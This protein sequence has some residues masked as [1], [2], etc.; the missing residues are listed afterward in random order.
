MSDLISAVAIIGGGIMGG[1]ISVVFASGGCKVHIVEPSPQ[2]RRD[3]PRRLATGWKSLNKEDLSSQVNIHASLEGV[4]WHSIQMVVECVYED[5]S[6]KRRI[7]AQ[8][9]T[10]CKNQTP[11]A[12]NSS[13]FPI[14]EISSEITGKRRT[15]GL[16]FFMPAHIVPLVEVICS[17]FTDPS[18]AEYVFT[19]IKHLGKHPVKVR[20]DVPGFLANRIQHALMREAIYL[21]E[22]GVASAED[23]DAAVR[24]G[25]GFR[26]IAAGPL[27]QKDMSGLDI[28]YNAAKNIYPDLCNSAKPSE[29]LRDLVEKG[30]TGMKGKQGFFAWTDEKSKR[31][32]D[33]YENILLKT[34]KIFEEER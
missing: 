7:F 3:L 23:V 20:R 18:I 19:A 14:S 16:H 17:E 1:D 4:P 27:L 34:V 5:L 26:Y 30:Y 6:L 8:L 29:Y 32:K 15:L 9:E 24:Y 25:F 22:S 13:S 10:L 31:E 12:S 33:R 11:L 2:T 21:V 28:Q